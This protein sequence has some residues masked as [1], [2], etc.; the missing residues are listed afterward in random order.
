MT[1]NVKENPIS[2]NTLEPS[3]LHPN[4]LTRQRGQEQIDTLY[5]TPVNKWSTSRLYSG[6]IFRLFYMVHVNRPIA[7]TRGTRI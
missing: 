5:S 3:S 7:F 2:E 1:H 6:G 4:V